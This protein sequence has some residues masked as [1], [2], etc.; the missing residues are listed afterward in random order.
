MDS[1]IDLSEPKSSPEPAL[2]N[3]G[4]SQFLVV[5]VLPIL[6]ELEFEDRFLRTA[7]L[8]LCWMSKGNQRSSNALA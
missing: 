8:G 1:R 6:A 5:E 2:R 7:P 3:F 4:S